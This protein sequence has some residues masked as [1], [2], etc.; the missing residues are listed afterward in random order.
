MD[1]SSVCCAPKFEA[2][3]SSLGSKPTLVMRDIFARYF[4]FAVTKDIHQVRC[5]PGAPTKFLSLAIFSVG[6]VLSK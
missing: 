3:C 6:S 2:G 1:V 4:C 5:F